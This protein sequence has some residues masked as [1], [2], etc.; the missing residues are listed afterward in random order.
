MRADED[1]AV[2]GGD[3]DGATGGDT[4]L[5][6]ERTLLAWQRTLIGVVIVVLLYLREPF[7]DGG[8]GPGSG[9]D[10]LYRLLVVLVVA[11]A[12]GVLMVHL[13]RRWR[14]TDRGLHDDAT[15]NP[16]APL[17]AGWAVYLLSGS[18]AGFALLVAVSAVV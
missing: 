12:A 15:Q 10:P 18:A 4:G 8:V 14:V 6:P 7:Q 1:T 5:Q 17:A 16:P 2:D 3:A 9:P 13:R 11:G